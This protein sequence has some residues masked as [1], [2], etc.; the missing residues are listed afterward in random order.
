MAIKVYS[1][2]IRE[3]KFFQIIHGKSL[4][5]KF[6]RIQTFSDTKFPQTFS[7]SNVPDSQSTVSAIILCR[8]H[9]P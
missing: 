6:C 3:N 4:D 1:K 9:V 7:E 8:I 2:T 5:E